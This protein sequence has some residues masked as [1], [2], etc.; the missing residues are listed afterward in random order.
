V[1][2]VIFLD[3]ILIF[4]KDPTKHAQHLTVILET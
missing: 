1:F 4:S 3:D 2:V